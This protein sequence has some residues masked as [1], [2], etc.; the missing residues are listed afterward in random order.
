VFGKVIKGMDVVENIARL[1]TGAGGAFPR[2]VPQQQ[3]VIEHI[4]VV[5]AK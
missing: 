2:D 5:E 3:V 1:P 4:R